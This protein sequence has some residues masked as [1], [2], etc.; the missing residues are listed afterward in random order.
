[1]RVSG[2][3]SNTCPA[4]LLIMAPQ[5]R[6]TL[7]HDGLRNE[8]A[9]QTRSVIGEYPLTDPTTV[10][11]KLATVPFRGPITIERSGSRTNYRSTCGDRWGLESYA[12][13]NQGVSWP[14][15]GP[16]RPGFRRHSLFFWPC[17]V[18]PV[19]NRARIAP[20]QVPCTSSSRHGFRRRRRYSATASAKPQSSCDPSASRI[21]V[22]GDHDA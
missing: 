11:D 21:L 12:R 10:H 5:G 2:G 7:A 13:S 19:S 17:T 14:P 20:S 6:K 22:A 4:G 3:A 8:A 16:Q 15:L 18:F 1:M 9:M